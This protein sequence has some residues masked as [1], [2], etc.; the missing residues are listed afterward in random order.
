MTPLEIQLKGIYVNLVKQNPN[1]KDNLH[2]RPAVKD[3]E[4]THITYED[5]RVEVI[6]YSTTID[7]NIVNCRMEDG[8]YPGNMKGGN[9]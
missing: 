6:L 9:R 4:L 5:N 7:G 3:G 2:I 8:S 1:L